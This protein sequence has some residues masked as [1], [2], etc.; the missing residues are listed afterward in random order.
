MIVVVF[1]PWRSFINENGGLMH[2]VSKAV[3]NGWTVF[4]G[5]GLLGSAFTCQHG[6]FLIAES[7]ERPMKKRR[8]KVTTRALL[9]CGVLEAAACGIMG[10]LAFLD[11]EG[12]V[13]NNF[14][15]LS[16]QN[17]R[18]AGNVGRI[19]ICM[20]MFFAY[21][22]TSFVIW[23]VFVVFFFRGRRTHEGNDASVLGRRNRRETMMAV[24]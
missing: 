22:V 10:F 11:T 3:A 9:L 14:L 18:R 13:I 19:L 24:W 7:L 16:S 6:A 2:I 12:N 1:D 23:H 21:P 20:T 4:I 5:L 17:M 8:V 15:E